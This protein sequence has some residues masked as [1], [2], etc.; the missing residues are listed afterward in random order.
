MTDFIDLSIYEK[1]SIAS[2]FNSSN[3][4]RIC[5]Y[6]EKSQNTNISCV[7]T[8]N[9]AVDT[10]ISIPSGA[11]FARLSVR[12]S[13]NRPI[14]KFCGNG[15]NAIVNSSNNINNTLN[16]DSVDNDQASSFFDDFQADS[17]GLS[18]IITAPLRLIQSLSSSSCSPLELPLPFVNQNAI[19]PC[20]STVYSQFATFYSLWQLITTGIIA[21]YI[22]IKLFGHIKG[23]QNPDDDRIEVLQ[24]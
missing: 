19:L 12:S 14:L 10:E 22:L 15:N 5:F 4:T 23:L 17:H 16:D 3:E 21:Y 24:L 18:G 2:P 1:I 11:N 8:N 20:M 9:V 7:N 6:S 13:S